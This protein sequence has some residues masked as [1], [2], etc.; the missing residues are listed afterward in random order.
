LRSQFAQVSLRRIDA[1]LITEYQRKRKEQGVGG[2]TV[3]LEIGLLRRIMK[4]N[5][6]WS[7]LAEDVTMLP[8][9]PKLVRIL[10]SEEKTRLLT[11]AASRPEWELAYLGAQLALNTTMRGCEL[12]GFCWA[13]I[14]LFAKT[15]VIRRSSTKTDAG[16]RLIPFNR[17]AIQAVVRLRHRAEQLGTSAP[18]HCVFPACESGHIDPHRPIKG[19][20]TARRSLTRAAGLRGIR[21]HDLRHQAITELAPNAAGTRPL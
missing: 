2:R 4:R 9:S 20:R 11:L 7:R 18:E 16:A 13:D 14:D 5:R 3:N 17:D 21:F 1:H 12:K 19:W 6:Q 10:S 15:F 8:E